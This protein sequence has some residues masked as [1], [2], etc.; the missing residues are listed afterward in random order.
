MDKK[1]PVKKDA[2]LK[3][4]DEL[5]QLDAELVAKTTRRNHI[6]QTM[7]ELFHTGESGT[8]NCE[9]YGYEVKVVRKL[10]ISCSKPAM[11]QLEADDETLFKLVFPRK[12]SRT[13]NATKAK[14][15]LD[16]L[17]DYVTT[18]QGLPTV[19]FKRVE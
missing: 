11:E 3:A 10:T 17:Q 9:A 12:V 6:R 5:E 18:K 7:A 16:E 14:E 15:K 8:E 2:F 13:L 19:T 4:M 1:L